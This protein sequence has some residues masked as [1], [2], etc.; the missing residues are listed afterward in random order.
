MG[1]RAIYGNLCR[2]RDAGGLHTVVLDRKDRGL[3]LA[4]TLQVYWPSQPTP[5]TMS[6]EIIMYIYQESF[7]FLALL[8][9]GVVVV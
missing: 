8:T 6:Q 2:V 5:R 4:T 1:I 9:F 3:T 7:W